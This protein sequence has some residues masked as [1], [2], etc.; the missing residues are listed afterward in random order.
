[1]ELSVKINIKNI[2][3]KWLKNKKNL[4]YVQDN[5]RILKQKTQNI[6]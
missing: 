5:Q 4:K 2:K 3:T 1:M 6:Y